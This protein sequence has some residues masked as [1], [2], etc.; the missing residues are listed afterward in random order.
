MREERICFIGGNS[1]GAC[2]TSRHKRNL[3]K[4]A[5]LQESSSALDERHARKNKYLKRRLIF[6]QPFPGGLRCL[7]GTFSICIGYEEICIS[8]L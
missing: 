8:I 1:T 2:A 6:D 4:C 7:R 5:R 3:Q